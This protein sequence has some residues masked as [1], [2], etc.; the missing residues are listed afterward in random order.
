VHFLFLGEFKR[1]TL[2]CEENWFEGNLDLMFLG[3]CLGIH[4]GALRRRGTIGISLCAIGGF[5]WRHCIDS[6]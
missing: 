2:F 3:V 4:V 5:S 6:V 1:S